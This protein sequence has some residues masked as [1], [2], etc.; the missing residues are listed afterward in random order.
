MKVGS[1]KRK[2]LDMKN[3]GGDENVVKKK[4]KFLLFCYVAY[5]MRIRVSEKLDRSLGKE[6]AGKSSVAKVQHKGKLV[7]HAVSLGSGLVRAN[8]MFCLCLSRRSLSCF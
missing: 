5:Q 6:T 8:G 7:P 3:S 4:S 1:K 2:K